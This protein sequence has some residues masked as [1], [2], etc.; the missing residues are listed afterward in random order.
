[1]ATEEPHKII[2]ADPRECK[3]EL[4][5]I[6]HAPFANA[7]EKAQAVRRVIAQAERERAATAARAKKG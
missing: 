3:F 1:M 7:A 2:E 4:P 6:D 5:P